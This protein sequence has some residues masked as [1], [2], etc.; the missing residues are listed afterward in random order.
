MANGEFSLVTMW[1]RP[2]HQSKRTNYNLDC[3]PY[4]SFAQ[5][6]YEEFK[7]QFAQMYE[8]YERHRTDNITDPALRRAHPISTIS[9]WE[10]ERDEN[11]PATDAHVPPALANGNGG[12]T[13]SPPPAKISKSEQTDD[14]DIV[15][16]K[17]EFH[18]I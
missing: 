16:G 5:V 17:Y 4:I 11:A 10:R 7:L 8:H 14:N 6:S 12:I 13:P 1:P 3:L 2:Q 15:S 18:K 9:G